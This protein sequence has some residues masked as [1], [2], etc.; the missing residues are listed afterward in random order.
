MVAAGYVLMSSNFSWNIWSGSHNTDL[1]QNLL[2]RKTPQESDSSPASRDG[3]E[4]NEMASFASLVKF[5]V[6]AFYVYLVFL[7]CYLPMLISLVATEMNGPNIPLKSWFVFSSTL[8]YLG[9]SLN[10]VIYCW[11][12]RPIRHAMMDIL[13]RNMPCLR[14]RAHH[15]S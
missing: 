9:S 11:K 15:I 5:A 3:G 10:P 7:I 2:N 13:P 14:N 8:F 1:H 4:R 6:G 12:M